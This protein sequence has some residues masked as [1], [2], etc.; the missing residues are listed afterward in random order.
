MR[1]H[2]TCL[3]V[4]HPVQHD[5][6]CPVPPCGHI[7]SHLLI[8]LARQPKVQDLVDHGYCVRHLRLCAT[9]LSI[10]P[11]LPLPIPSARSLRSPLRCWA[12][13]PAG[14]TGRECCG[15]E[16]RQSWLPLTLAHSFTYPVDDACRVDILQGRADQ[17]SPGST[18]LC[19]NPERS[20]EPQSPRTPPSAHATAG[21]RGTEHAHHL[22]FDT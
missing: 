5:L 19:P 10:Q 15:R 21:R 14:W 17:V 1:V 22:V 13:S 20:R 4:V 9:P 16:P 11:S 8:S 7:S 12:S 2:S 3:I 18:P 6:W